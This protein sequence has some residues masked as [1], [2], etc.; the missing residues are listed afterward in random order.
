MSIILR[1]MYVL[2]FMNNLKKPLNYGKK[3]VIILTDIVKY[4]TYIAHTLNKVQDWGL[5]K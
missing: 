4:L 5:E 1:V 3:F 2:I